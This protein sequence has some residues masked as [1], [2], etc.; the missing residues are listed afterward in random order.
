MLPPL[1]QTSP[2]LNVQIYIYIRSNPRYNIENKN[3]YCDLKTNIKFG[4][5]K[6]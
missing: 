3:M 2:Q 1:A 4:E 6:F 5:V